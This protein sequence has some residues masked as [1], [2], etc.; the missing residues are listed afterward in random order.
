[1]C[2]VEKIYD[3][4]IARKVD[5]AGSGRQPLQS[6]HRKQATRALYS[7]VNRSVVVGLSQKQ[8]SRRRIYRPR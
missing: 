2:G 4:I 6:L 7:N 5:A 8:L 3:R 1:M